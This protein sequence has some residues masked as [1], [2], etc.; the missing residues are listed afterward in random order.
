[1]RPSASAAARWT[2]GP[3]GLQAP[4]GAAAAR[5]RRASRPAEC[6]A[7]WR[8][9]SSRS[10]SAN[11][12]A[13]RA[14]GRLDARE[15]PDGV[16]PR[17]RRTPTFS[18]VR[19]S[20]GTAPLPS[21]PSWRSARLCTAGRASSSS[22]ASSAGRHRVPGEAEAA[23]VV[24]ARRALAADAVDRAEHV[25][26]GE[27]RGGTAQL[28]PRAG[29]DHEQAAVGIFEHVG[30]M[31]IAAARHEEIGIAALERRAARLEHV[32]RHL[33]QVEQR[34]EEVVAI[35]VAEDARARSAS[36]RTAP[37]A[38]S[39]SA[40]ASGRPF[41]CDRRSPRAA[42]RRRRR[43]WRESARRAGRAAD[44]RE[45]WRSGSVRRRA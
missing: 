4:R 18:H 8:T 25:R 34:R 7:A 10:S 21:L 1:M 32:A 30:R 5:Q 22:A 39:A 17:L 43:R 6:S 16:A 27:L 19:S 40:P 35:L 45:R 36:G 29:V 33:V 44:A 38:R 28:V 37:R 15:R 23:R 24:T 31:K 14:C 26:L 3:A 9:L 11:R 12:T 2:G 41:A 13:S 20:A 42:F